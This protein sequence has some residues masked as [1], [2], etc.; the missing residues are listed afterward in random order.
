MAV[1]QHAPA[2]DHSVSEGH[3]GAGVLGYHVHGRVYR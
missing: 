3:I 2:L 1:S